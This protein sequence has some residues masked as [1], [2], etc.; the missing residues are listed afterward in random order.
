MLVAWDI[1]VDMHKCL[2]SRAGADEYFA[3]PP[4]PIDSLV[5]VIDDVVACI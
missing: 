4:R 1:S 3:L 2:A 5:S